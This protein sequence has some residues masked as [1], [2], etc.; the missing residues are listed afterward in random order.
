[1]V[2]VLLSASVER[3]ILSG[4]RDFFDQTELDFNVVEQRKAT[5]K[6]GGVIKVLG[7]FVHPFN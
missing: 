6:L 2:S 7:S 3:F 1:M 5:N 4:M